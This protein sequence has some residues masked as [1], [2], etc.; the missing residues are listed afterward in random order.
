MESNNIEN[1]TNEKKEFKIQKPFLKWVGGKSQIIQKVIDKFPKNINNYYEIF[2]G[3]G[4]VL[5]ALLSMKKY[6]LIN[7]QNK[8]FAYDLNADLINVYKTIQNIESRDKLFN[9]LFKIVK[10]YNSITK[11]EEKDLDNVLNRKPKNKKEAM[12]CK[13]NYY[14]WIRS[15]YNNMNTSVGAVDVG[16]DVIK[17][18]AIF[19]F[20]NKTGFRG[21]YRVGPN[22]FNIPYGHY[23]K[24]PKFFTKK[25]YDLIS[26]LIQDV[27][28]ICCSFE[29][30]LTNFVKGDF[31]YL[32]PP[33]APVDKKSFVGYTNDGFTYE[34]HIKLFDMIKNIIKYDGVKILMSN[35]KVKLVEDNFCQVGGDGNGDGDGDGDGEKKK[36]NIEDVLARRAINSKNPGA[37]AKEVLIWN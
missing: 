34:K 26:D 10:E 15:K 16:D 29:T 23:K 37:K 3:G 22:G 25:E 19:M 31:I 7:V 21:M 6:G 18:S 4:S 36:F 1:K 35:A 28:F 11:V 13:E 9:Y 17:K 24:T 32:D 12:L 14:Y 8:I 20:L 5:F 2:L 27:E 30:S 33:Y